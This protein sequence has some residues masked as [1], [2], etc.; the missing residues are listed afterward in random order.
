MQACSIAELKELY[1][2]ILRHEAV[3]ICG[4]SSESDVIGKP[5]SIINP[6]HYLTKDELFNI[7][8]SIG[9]KEPKVCIDA[10]IERGFLVKLNLNNTDEERYRSYPF[11]FLLHASDLRFAPWTDR[12][13]TQTIFTIGEQIIEDFTVASLK[14]S[15]S[16]NSI[17]E[18]KELWNILERELGHFAKIYAGVLERYMQLRGSKGLTYFQLYSLLIAL[19][20]YNDVKAIAIGAPAGSGKTEIFLSLMLFKILKDLKEGRKSKILIIYPRKFLEIDQ[21]QR[22]IEFIRILNEELEGKVQREVTVAIRDGDTYELERLWSERKDADL[23]FRGIRCEYGS[24]YIEAS[25]GVIVCKN[26]NN[27]TLKH[28]YNFVKWRRSESKAADII[29]TNLHTFFNRI[30]TSKEDDLNATDLLMHTPVEMIVLDEAHEYEPLELGLLHYMFK[31]L[32][33]FKDDTKN[34]VYKHHVKLIIST[35]TLANMNEFVKTLRAVQDMEAVTI[36]YDSVMQ[37]LKNKLKVVER[38]GKTTITRKLVI[39]GIVFVHPSFSWET[40]VSQLAIVSLYTNFALEHG[41]KSR[42]AIKQAII[43]LNNVRELNRL[44]TIIANDLQLGSPFANAGLGEVYSKRDL[45]PV[46]H[47]YSLRHYTEMLYRAAS[48]DNKLKQ[49]LENIVMKMN[50]KDE[51]YSK[52]RKVYADV[53]LQGRRIIAEMI[54]NKELYIVIA[55]SSLELGVDYPGVSI[56]INVG[57]DKLPSLIQRFG[58][59]GRSINEALHTTLALIIARNNPLEYVKV[60]RLLESGLNAL[61]TGSISNIANERML[62]ELEVNVGHDLIGAKKVAVMRILFMLNALRTLNKDERIKKEMEELDPFTSVKEEEECK[63]LVK[64][65]N[66]LNYNK[67][68]IVKIVDSSTV[69]V[70]LR[71]ILRYDNADKCKAEREGMKKVE[72]RITTLESKLH[73]L[74]DVCEHLGEAIKTISNETLY[75]NLTQ[76][77]DLCNSICGACTSKLDELKNLV[78]IRPDF[79]TIIKSIDNLSSELTKRVGVLCKEMLSIVSDAYCRENYSY[80]YSIISNMFDIC[81]EQ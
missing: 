6:Q 62:E 65:R 46:R 42:H 73:R 71:E 67:D 70:V 9:I 30:I 17:E 18:E 23:E 19:K 10:L 27:P 25:T 37:Q 56:V 64:L 35:A 38:L 5:C 28:Y 60:F 7:A 16:E 58:R 63:K 76:M 39:L 48:I 21:A 61:V 4:A 22:I 74:C 3:R 29:I 57:L 32:N 59:A 15:D 14:P 43:F 13:V 20:N 45:D 80:C 8:N 1:H 31:F 69:E 51:L 26:T 50:A 78:S 44:H 24:L 47:R 2:A 34:E 75:N 54:R 49:L 55:T 68:M 79:D 36:A 77:Y 81:K 53:D 12:M 40:F 41:L 33:Y 66:F 72:E 52:L 11:D